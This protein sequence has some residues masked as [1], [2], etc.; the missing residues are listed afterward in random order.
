[1]ERAGSW[2]TTRPVCI[3]FPQRTGHRHFRPRYPQFHQHLSE[4]VEGP[5]G[6]HDGMLKGEA[7]AWQ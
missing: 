3:H 4:E 6:M 2:D 5:G 7:Q 1:V